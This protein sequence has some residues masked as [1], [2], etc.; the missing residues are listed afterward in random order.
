MCACKHA[1]L[2]VCVRAHACALVGRGGAR[3]RAG[4]R[5]D[6]V[7]PLATSVSDAP[8]RDGQAAHVAIRSIRRRLE[9][10]GKGL[11]LL[12]VAMRPQG[13]NLFDSMKRISI[14]SKE[15]LEHKL[16]T[17]QASAI[18]VNK[19]LLLLQAHKVEEAKKAIQELSKKFSGDSRVTIVEAA[20]AW[21]T[22]KKSGKAEE[23]L[24]NYLIDLI[25]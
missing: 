14:A 21:E 1:R 4:S 7:C 25:F 11:Q 16:S 2:H 10:Q 18:A 3:A 8:R 23:I 6:G 20:L 19:C 12:I 9:D 5:A 15:S 13:K 17:K 24:Q 22:E